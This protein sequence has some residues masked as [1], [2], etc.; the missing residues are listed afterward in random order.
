MAVAAFRDTEIGLLPAD[1]KVVTV[2]SLS[3]FVTSGSRGW[4]G[5][6]DEFGDPFIRITN[7]TR[8]SIHLDLEDL[9]YVRLPQSA[10]EGTRT[11][12]RETDVLISITADIGIVACVSG[13]VPHPAY[14]NQHIALVRFDPTAADGRFVA[15]YLASGPSQ[16]IFRSMTDTGAKAGMNLTS[17]Q[18]LKIPLP[19]LIEQRAIADALTDVD[20]LA[21]STDRLI[22][23]KKD[24][25]SGAAQQLLGGHIRLP[26]HTADWKTTQFGSIAGL[27]RDRIDPRR[28]GAQPFCVELEHIAQDAGRLLG[29][30]VATDQASIKSVFRPGDVLFGKLRSYLRKFWLADRSGVC[31]TEIWVLVANGDLV[32][33]SYLFQMVKTDDFIQ[34][35]STSYGTHM[36]R[37]DWNT[38]E[39][40]EVA[41]PTLDEQQQ[42]AAVLEDMDAEILSLEHQRAK[43]TGLKTAMLQDLLSGRTRLA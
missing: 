11:S 15:Y 5:Y 36:P 40:Y 41:L 19:S 16:K 32:T 30:T 22:S 26:G 8:S 7:M 39:K 9:R 4:A 34:A 27:S 25:R 42:I 13:S 6:Y 17:I 37:S 20:A 18:E 21:D 12:L 24:L 3:P 33:P 14:I 31:S 29:S 28:A 10:R 43:A 1:W 35:A 38:L 23:K 2:G